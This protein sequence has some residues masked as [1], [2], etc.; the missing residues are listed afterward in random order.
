[1]Q[2]AK[3]VNDG[4][5][6]QII[7]IFYERKAYKQ[8]QDDDENEEKNTFH[9]IIQCMKHFRHWEKSDPKARDWYPTSDIIGYAR[10]EFGR[11]FNP[12]QLG[13]IIFDLLQIASREK[14]QKRL[15]IDGKHARSVK[16]RRGVIEGKAKQMFDMDID[17]EE[18]VEVFE[19]GTYIEF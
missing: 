15:T 17:W 2:I 7:D 19:D 8:H 3:L 9:A 5:L 10:D 4:L 14:D 6:S 12:R 13:S 16:L 11:D 18:P 1:M